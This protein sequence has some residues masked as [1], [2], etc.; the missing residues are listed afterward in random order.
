MKLTHEQRI[1]EGWLLNWMGDFDVVMP[2]AAFDA[3]RDRLAAHPVADAAVASE[4]DCWAIL[5][6]NG[7]RLVSP[8]EAKGRR[9]AYPLYRADAIKSAW[10]RGYTAGWNGDREAVAPT[11]A[12]AAVAPNEHCN[13]CEQ[14]YDPACQECHTSSMATRLTEQNAI[15][16]DL[17]KALAYWMPKAFDDRSSHD[18]YLLIGYD[19]EDEVGYW[20]QREA[21][22]PDERAAFEAWWV[23]DV[24]ESH[25]QYA[26]QNLQQSRFGDGIYGSRR[27]QDAWIGWQAR[28]TAPQSGE[29]DGEQAAW[30][31]LTDEDR[32]AAFESLPDMLEGFMKKW[33]WLNF[34]KEIERRCMEK[35]ARAAVTQAGATLTG[36]QIVEWCADFSS[37]NDLDSRTEHRLAYAL[38]GLFAAHPSTGEGEPR[39]NVQ[40][41]GSQPRQPY[42]WRDTGALETGEAG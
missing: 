14:T 32:K 41:L 17:Q 22:Q 26:L 42:A 21:A 27:A 9:D 18:A 7:S 19:G 4:P 35:N 36:E 30:V 29:K 15:I 12:D 3:L 31:A 1:A 10:R 39:E 20:E 24:P 11:I 16:R 5:T 40:H 23:R 34:A 28:A 8:D 25:R 13:L 33:G 6:P 38:R 37:A 2:S